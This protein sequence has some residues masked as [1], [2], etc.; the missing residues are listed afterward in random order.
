MTNTRSKVATEPTANNEIANKIDLLFETSWEVCNKVGGIYAVLSTKARVLNE[1]FGEKLAFIGPDLWTAENPSPYFKE[2]KS[3]FKSAAAKL[4][5][6]WGIKIRTGRWNIPGSPQVILVNVG[7]TASHLPEVYA[8]MW[9]L[10]GVDSLHA[11]GDYDEGCTFAIASAIVIKALTEYLKA[12]PARVIAHF[13]EWTTGMGLLYTKYS[14]PKAATIFTTHATCIGRSICG[15]G[16]PLYDQFTHYDGDQMA[17]ELNMESKHS[18]EKAAAHQADCF[19]TVSEVTAAECSQLLRRPVDVVTPNGF[20]P[21]FVPKTMRYNRL[22]KDGRTHLLEIARALTGQEFPESTFMIATSGRHEYRNKGLDMFLDAIA[23]ID[24]RLPEDHAALAFILVPGWVNRPSESLLTSLG[25]GSR[26]YGPD[27]LTHRLNNEDSDEV[28]CRIRQLQHE[29]AFRHTRV[30]Y[31]PCYLDGGDGI[32]N[33][34][35]YDLLPA[36]DLTLFPSYY[37][38]WGYTPLESVAFGVPTVTDNKAGFGQWVLDNF[39]NGIGRCGVK[40]VERSDSG[41]EHTRSEIAQATLDYE[42]SDASSRLH[43]R[44]MAFLTAVKTDWKYFI[45]HY[46][47]AFDIALG[48]H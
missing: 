23:E 42:D 16:K 18:L 30:I 37:E 46:N 12:D 13:D 41:Y 44:N 31:V 27:Y 19:T 36:F 1:Q 4:E 29:G 15:N 14:M 24:R 20:E 7:D 28:C 2:R 32:V 10:Y 48:K 3:T 33:I 9:E 6:P 25:D 34:S 26:N 35:Y 38:P 47:R 8:K 40:V 22:R 39:E 17:R 43:A 45:E 11:Y 5:L 21:D